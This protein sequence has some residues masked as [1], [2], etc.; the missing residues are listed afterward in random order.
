MFRRKR[1]T[2][3]HQVK[4]APLSTASSQSAQSAATHAFLKSQPSSS[5]LSSAAAAA[6]L[7]S[8]TP[9]PTP[10]ENVQTK[11]MMQRRASVTSQASM[12]TTLR[13]VSRTDLRRSNSSS[14]MSN[15]TFR[16]Q[17]P[18]RPFTSTGQVDVVPP[19]PSMPPGI[20]GGK[21]TSRRSVSLDPSIRLRS[22]PKQRPAGRGLSVDR[23]LKTSAS[24]SPLQSKQLSTVPE[25][26]RSGSRNSINFSY[27]IAARPTSPTVSPQLPARDVLASASPNY[28]L[29][30]AGSPNARVTKNQSVRKSTGLAPGSP[31]RTVPSKGTAVAAAQAAIV[32]RDEMNHS[33][34]SARSGYIRESAAPAQKH[35]QDDRKI[36]TQSVVAKQPH[37]VTENNKGGKLAEAIDTGSHIDQVPRRSILPIEN[38]FPKP[39]EHVYAAEPSIIRTPATPDEKDGFQ[40]TYPDHTQ[41]TKD[42]VKLGHGLQQSQNRPTSTSPG[43][44]ARFSSQLAVTGN[45]EHQPPARSASPVKSALKNARKSSLSPDGRNGGILR[46]VP[47]L[48]ELS[49][50]TSVASDD[51]SRLGSRRKP[52]KV[53]FDDEAEVVGVAASPPTS[54]EDMAPGTPERLKSKNGWFPLGKRM[55]SQ[56]DSTT[57]DEFD[58]VLRPRPALPSFGSIRGSRETPSLSARPEFSDNESTASSEYDTVVSGWSYS[59]NHA[60]GGISSNL[61]LKDLRPVTELDSIPPPKLPHDINS[62]SNATGEIRNGSV[63][64]PNSQVTQ[65]GNLSTYDTHSMLGQRLSSSADM[66][67]VAQDLMDRNDSPELEK[68]RSS[69]EQYTV[70]GGFPRT[71]LELDSKHLSTKK[72]KKSRDRRVDDRISTEGSDNESEESVYSDA[73]EVVEGD[74][75]GSINAIVDTRLAQG[76]DSRPVDASSSNELSTDIT[77]E[78]P[79]ESIRLSTGLEDH[80]GGHA[81]T[82]SKDTVTQHASDSP[83]TS[84]NALP[85]SSPYPLLSTPSTT[86]GQSTNGDAGNLS[87]PSGTAERPMSTVGYGDSELRNAPSSGTSALR[88][89]GTERVKKRPVSFVPAIQKEIVTTPNNGTSVNGRE[90]YTRRRR[91]SDGSDSSSSFIR[92][93]PRARQDGL[94]S[95]RRT[96]RGGPT[97]RAPQSSAAR[98]SSPNEARPLSSGSGTGT[99]RMTLRANGP[100]N[101]KTPIFAS[102]RS[103]K[104]KIS[105]ATGP[106]FMSR[107]PDS[108]DED[109]DF[110]RRRLQYHYDDSSDDDAD[111]VMQS[112]RPVR[113]I[114]RRQG[115]Y[116]GDSTEL[117]DSSD[118][119]RPITPAPAAASKPRPLSHDPGLAAVAKSRGMTEEELDEFLHRQPKGRMSGILG[120]FALK[121]SKRPTDHRMSKSNMG[122]FGQDRDESLLNPARGSTI[123][124]VSANNP[125]PSPSKLTKGGAKKTASGSWPLHPARKESE[126]PANVESVTEQPNGASRSTDSHAVKQNLPAN[127]ASENEAASIID[128]GHSV[129]KDSAEEAQS[130]PDEVQALRSSNDANGPNAKDIVFPPGGRKKRFFSLRKAFGMRD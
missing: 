21:N 52:V 9:T 84:Q 62:Q 109:A 113:G 70:P 98:A 12:S 49:D 100:K 74:G 32:P 18:H 50:A 54:P 42:S 65:P 110:R 93:S 94:H 38:R 115:T 111:R 85:S 87:M 91:M 96:M 77:R 46:P 76:K 95:M 63:L 107:F 119:E 60:T 26:E 56:L 33:P 90:P 88:K 126:A 121:K 78:F 15:R 64:E 123:T 75:F 28:D 66:G 58:E 67:L 36:T 122:D 11:R 44:S 92:S 40:P 29:S 7:R 53:S 106:R 125:E 1:S 80:L 27:P 83:A 16:E 47:A 22:S 129:A 102:T 61:P 86:L 117:E 116:D 39:F 128:Q 19:L 41:E 59:D 68:G 4:L 101:E 35:N 124:T 55:T 48:S 73:E 37:T 118:N 108:D 114:P 130:A 23:S 30:P 31:G 69:L 120:R 13:P 8:L 24:Q 104:S 105:K 10:V 71:S 34:A 97:I 20:M 127:G 103:P 89:A 45:A 17:S 112:F 14:S 2:S 25:V 3:R 82:S 51:G 5:S 72:G 99:M 6:A 43:R 81:V 79:V 57:P